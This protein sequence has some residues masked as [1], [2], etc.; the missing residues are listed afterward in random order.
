MDMKLRKSRTEKAK[1][2]QTLNPKP[3]IQKMKM[4]LKKSRTE[5]AVSEPPPGETHK[6]VYGAKSIKSSF[7]TMSKGDGKVERGRIDPF[8][9][10]A[11]AV[12]R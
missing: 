6:R 12:G 2:P 9:N 10:A 11:R 1:Q 5:K 3:S 8:E 4:K 7:F